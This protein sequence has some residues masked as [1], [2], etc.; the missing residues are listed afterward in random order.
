MR[1]LTTSPKTRRRPTRPPSETPPASAA[2]VPSLNAVD[3]PDA[4]SLDVVRDTTTD[5]TTDLS[6]DAPS[7]DASDVTVDTPVV[8]T[9]AVDAPVIDA[10]AELRCPTTFRYTPPAGRTVSR[11]E[12]TGEWSM[13]SNPGAAMRADEHGGYTVDLSLAPG[14]HAYKLLIDGNWELDPDAARRKYVGGLEKLG[15][16]RARLPTADA[17]ARHERRDARLDGQRR[18][19]RG[20]LDQAG[21]R[22]GGRRSRDGARDAR[23]QRELARA[24]GRDLRRRDGPRDARSDGPRRRQVHRHRHRFRS[25]GTRRGA[26]APRVLGRG[27]RPSPGRARRSTWR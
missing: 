4:P 2:D 14:L 7:M 20:G 15:R 11:V 17:H 24:H 10:P 9:P 21:R 6:A 18:L 5:V 16:A 13:W 27:Q 25:R 1:S 8:D 3:V 19:S 12:V 23:P 22:R 26:A